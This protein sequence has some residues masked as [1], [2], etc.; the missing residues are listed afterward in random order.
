MCLGIQA[1][2]Y[3]HACKLHNPSVLDSLVLSPYQHL[4]KTTLKITRCN[5]ILSFQFGESQQNAKSQEYEISA[6][7][8][9][10]PYKMYSADCLTLLQRGSCHE[11][12]IACEACTNQE[13]RLPFPPALKINLILKKRSR[14]ANLKLLSRNHIF[15]IYFSTLDEATVFKYVLK[16]TGVLISP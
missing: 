6:E 10:K 11:S 16:I 14:S 7:T 1:V 5:S 15:L 12:Y 8:D 13:I 9:T 2:S 4:V 3:L